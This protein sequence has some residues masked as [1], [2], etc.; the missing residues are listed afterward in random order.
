MVRLA[1]W[2]AGFGMGFQIMKIDDR[3]RRILTLLQQDARMSNA[4]LAEAVGMSPSAL[5]RR[6]RALETGGVIERYGAIVNP[7]AMGLGFQAIVQCT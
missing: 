4:D 5:W 1:V 3:D 6:V 2:A 7:A